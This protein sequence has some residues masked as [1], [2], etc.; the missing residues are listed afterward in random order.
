MPLRFEHGKTRMAA[1]RLKDVS[2]RPPARDPS[3]GR[4]HGGRF[5]AGNSISV[6]HGWK[7]TIRKWLG[8]SVTDDAVVD[9]LVRDA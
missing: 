3:D 6:G 9:E 4:A 1:P 2:A 5:A 8:A 7:A